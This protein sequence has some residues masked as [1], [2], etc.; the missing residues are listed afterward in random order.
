MSESF[1]V[2]LSYNSKDKL[3][4][5]QLAK[6]LQ[7]RG[8]QVWL[9]EEQLVPGRRWQEALEEIIQT[10]DTAAVLIGTDGLGPW[11]KSEMRAFVLESVRRDLSVIPVFL[12]DA[13][14]ELEL[15]LFLRAFTWVDL[16]GGLTDEG[17]DRLEWGITGIK[18]E[19]SGGKPNT[20][21]WYLLIELVPR[22]NQINKFI[23][24]AWLAEDSRLKPLKI[25]STYDEQA[26][27]IE[28]IPGILH[29]L[30]NYI[31]ESVKIKGRLT[32]EFIVPKELLCSE[33]D[34]WEDEGKEECRY[35][36]GVYFPIVVRCRERFRCS[37]TVIHLNWS[38]H[39][40]KCE[41]KL[42]RRLRPGDLVW[43]D[44]NHSSELH[45][46]LDSDRVICIILTFVPEALTDSDRKLF[47]SQLIMAG[48]PIA[49]WPRKATN[50]D[51]LRRIS[52]G[53]I[54]SSENLADLPEAVRKRRLE[55]WDPQKKLHR[56]PHL[57]LLWDDY[58]RRV[59]QYP[60]EPP[61][62]EFLS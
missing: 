22:V 12:P 6:D 58:R 30:L 61:K 21:N 8:L 43:I 57:T 23:I 44:S 4:A 51:E 39:W 3:T 49:L 46:K 55:A 56:E 52:E 15:P 47:L 7:E 33:I 29:E 17:L 5:R 9:D 60:L 32:L 41:A 20:S 59:P 28:E 11:E 14:T 53:I 40:D 10:A 38:R 50:P 1:D 13:P 35:P 2:F 62:T 24:Q 42:Y 54:K 19:S 18:P 37:Y 31:H 27:T 34:F 45:Q 26:R 25:S 36:F 48:T 16:R